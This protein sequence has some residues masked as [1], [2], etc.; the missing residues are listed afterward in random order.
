[1][2]SVFDERIRSRAFIRGC[3]LPMPNGPIQW[4]L[5][6]HS[7]VI[8]ISWRHPSRRY[9]FSSL[10]ASTFVNSVRRSHRL[11]IRSSGLYE[12]S[13]N[14]EHG[15]PFS[16]AQ[17]GLHTGRLYGIFSYKLIQVN[18]LNLNFRSI[19]WLKFIWTRKNWGTIKF[20]NTW[21]WSRSLNW[22]LN[23]MNGNEHPEAS[24]FELQEASLN[25]LKILRWHLNLKMA[26]NLKTS[27]LI[28]WIFWMRML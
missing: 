10:F 21:A 2:Q 15:E 1:M 12:S 22:M 11:G 19:Y 6:V 26:L 4:M 17:N 18:F 27:I 23:S 16:D 3:S 7:A 25:L 9:S 8:I 5:H 13:A 24:L 14:A 20:V 28:W